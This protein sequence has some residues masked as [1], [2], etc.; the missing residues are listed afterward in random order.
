MH[1]FTKTKW[2]MDLLHLTLFCMLSVFF[3]EPALENETLSESKNLK[4]MATTNVAVPGA[5]NIIYQSKDGGQTWQDVSQTLPVNAQPEGFFAGEADVYMRVKNELYRSKSNLKEP[6]WEKETALDLLGPSIAFNRSGVVAY[7]YDGQIYSKSLNDKT[8]SPVYTTAKKHSLQ[9]VFE[10]TDGTLFLGSGN[11]LYKSA[12][13]GRSWKQVHNEGWVMDIV[14]SDGVLIGTGEKGI[15]R[16]TDKGEHWEWVIS[17]G[18]VGIA[19]ERIA[20][21]FAAIAYNS[22]KQARRIY[23][24][25][26]NGKTWKTIDEGLQPSLSISSI[27]QVGNYLLCGH[28]DGIYR[29]ADMGKTWH[30]VQ[31]GVAERKLIF[32]PTWNTATY[33]D[34]DKVFKLFVAGGVIYAVAVNS[35]C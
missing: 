34:P 14:E 10:T 31:S 21:G 25:M 12:D 13:K 30:M 15:M 28:P 4:C 22:T 7:N 18:G 33:N 35:G 6:T 9:S 3:S 27:K 11:G 2:I 20:G 17:E 1:S 16:S 32:V 19:V 26:D 29:S 23:T 5:S 8:W 24:S